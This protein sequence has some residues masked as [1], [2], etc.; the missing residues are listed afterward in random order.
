MNSWLA[1]VLASLAVFS[2]KFMGY[3]LPS[4]LLESKLLTRIA[5]YLTIA[6]LAGLVGVQTFSTGNKLEFDARIPAILMAAI[7]LKIKA[8]FIVIVLAAGATAAFLRL[9]F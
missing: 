8:P 5:G 6:L 3:L 4:K 9:A 7:L 1:I 2:W